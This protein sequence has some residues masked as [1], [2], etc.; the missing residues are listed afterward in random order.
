VEA[1]R[2]LVVAGRSARPARIMTLNQIRHL[3][4]TGPEELR[5]RL[6]GVSRHHL[7]ARAAALR[8]GQREG[9]DPVM[10]AARTALRMPGRRVLALDEEKARTGALLAPLVTATAPQLLTVS[11]ARHRGR[12]A[13]HRGG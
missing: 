12:A 2:A 13:G 8:P 1:I 5:A 7:A 4:F 11:G 10:A 9:A 6:K 3:S